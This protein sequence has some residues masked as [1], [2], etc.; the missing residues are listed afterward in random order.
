MKKK[1]IKALLF[2]GLLFIVA[3]F[4]L[5]DRSLIVIGIAFF[6]WYFIELKKKT[7]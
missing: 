4:F 2:G 5:N 6:V 1:N 7:A 3:S